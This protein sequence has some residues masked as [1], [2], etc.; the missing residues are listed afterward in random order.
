MRTLD[1]D[2]SDAL[3]SGSFNAYIKVHIGKGAAGELAYTQQVIKYTL[4][5]LDCTVICEVPTTT[6]SNM[7]KF[8]IE[9]GITEDGTPN[10]ISTCFFYIDHLAFN[11]RLMS[12]HGHVFQPNRQ[13]TIN[14]A[15]SYE[16]NIGAA[17]SDHSCRDTYENDTEDWLDYIMVPSNRV[18][19]ES[20]YLFTMLRQKYLIYAREQGHTLEG[21][22][23]EHFSE[24]ELFCATETIAVEYTITD[25]LFYFVAG[26][27]K[28]YYLWKDQNGAIHTSGTLSYPS[29][30]LG[31][32]LDSY[33]P[34][35]NVNS[36]LP[37]SRAIVPVHLKYQ[38]GDYITINSG[39]GD[40]Q[41]YTGRVEVIEVLDIR[42]QPS[43]YCVIKPLAH[44]SPTVPNLSPVQP[45]F[46]NPWW[47]PPPHSPPPAPP[48]E[49]PPPLTFDPND[50][51]GYQG[52][53]ASLKNTNFASSLDA[54]VDDLQTLAEMVDSFPI[55]LSGQYT[56]TLTN[57][58][59]IDASVAFSCNYFR[60][61]DFVLVSGYCT[62]DPTA[63][64]TIYLGITL[65]I[66]TDIT[67]VAQASGIGQNLT[68]DDCVIYG[69]ITND[70]VTLRSPVTSAANAGWYF[71]FSYTI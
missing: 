32:M 7:T 16:V 5:A 35:P 52:Y 49:A 67:S 33:D 58:L 61:G 25:K 71:F 70:R 34:P 29:H 9:R 27:D 17:F 54:S 56:P 51:R 4:T 24:I 59:N 19:S 46:L 11:G 43:W 20:K 2:L 53:T 42:H 26:T 23:L 10:T 8:Y 14:A 37:G 21:A 31:Y 39:M 60:L 15:N 65:P 47:T 48:P 12:L 38:T 28:R 63:V 62:I 40:L 45:E 3:D 68:P 41:S 1:S 6:L 55:S 44:F 36:P 64:G 57:V 50:P 13:R 69:D 18:L 30:N 66:A 22:L